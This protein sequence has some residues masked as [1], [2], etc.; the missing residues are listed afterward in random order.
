M[1]ELNHDPIEYLTKLSFE[2][3]DKSDLHKRV[4]IYRTYMFPHILVPQLKGTPSKG[5]EMSIVRSKYTK[6]I[7]SDSW[8]IL[9]LEIDKHSAHDKWKWLKNTLIAC[10]E[11]NMDLMY[12][13]RNYMADRRSLEETSG[14][15]KL[16]EKDS[17]RLYAFGMASPEVEEEK[18]NQ[19]L[20]LC[21][22]PTKVVQL[23]LYALVDLEKIE[24]HEAVSRLNDEDVF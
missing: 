13:I 1:T 7:D 3:Y 10:N 21:Y 8:E 11:E 9:F 4:G 20:L 24:E 16:L 6:T 19:D 18:V 12:L 14:L 17:D 5:L 2:T 15:N 22:V 23:L